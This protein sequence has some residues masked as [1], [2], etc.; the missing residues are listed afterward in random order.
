MSVKEGSRGLGVV[1]LFAGIG[2]LEVGLS[3][4]GHRAKLLCEIDPGATSVLKARFPDV[5]IHNDITTLPRLPHGTDL[6]AAGFPCQDLSQAGQTRGI[7]GRQSG[8]VGHVFRLLETQNVPWVLLENVPFMLQLNRGAAMRYIADRLEDLGYQWAYRVIDTRAFGLPQRR[9][10]VYLLASKFMDRATML[11]GGN[12]TPTEPDEI[13][14]SDCGFYWTEGLRGI[15]W[16]VDAVPTLKGGST[17]GIPSPP[18]IWTTEGAFVT[19]DIR[20]AERL[21]GF[22][23]DWTGPS[24]EVAKRGHRWKLVGNSVSVPVAEWLGARLNAVNGR[25]PVLAATFDEHRGWPRAA[26]SGDSGRLA[27]RVST[28]PVKRAARPLRE[29]LRYS[30]RPLSERAL[31]GFWSRLSRSSLNRPLQFDEDIRRTL[32]LPPGAATSQ[33]VARAKAR[34]TSAPTALLA[35]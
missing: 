28:W 22:E 15:G 17:I 16:A 2:G 7:V 8:L 29:F 9:E 33:R 31:S 11:F 24:E 4:A 20:D 18:A 25:R 10:R 21:Q 26:M 32:G 6:V 35:D 27:V 14:R 30:T 1:G 12:H 3:R 19:P 23:S 5:R 13:R 34:S